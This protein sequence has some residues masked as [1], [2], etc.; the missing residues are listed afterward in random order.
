MPSFSVKGGGGWV[1]AEGYRLHWLA[2]N[3]PARRSFGGRRTPG[4]ELPGAEEGRTGVSG[5]GRR[6]GPCPGV[7]SLLGEDVE[8]R[9]AA[10]L[11]FQRDVME[12]VQRIPGVLA[13][14]A[15]DGLPF[16]GVVSG[17]GY[18]V[19]APDGENSMQVMARNHRVSRGYSAWTSPFFLVGSWTTKG[20]LL[21]PF[22]RSSST[23]PWPTLL[24][25]ASPLDATIWRN[26]MP[27]R[28]GRCG[29]RAGTE[30]GSRASTH[31]LPSSFGDHG[32]VQRRGSRPGSAG[33]PGATAQGGR[34]FGQ[35]Q[36]LCPRK[37]P[38]RP[39]S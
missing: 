13:S 11:E 2:E 26:R 20:P 3:W 30:S 36:P 8:G 31:G 34:A 37:T 19:G 21:I 25:E 32:W 17:N 7:F 14:G 1:V 15:I 6:H 12:R 5:P 23:K 22:P 39:S 9:R 35:P 27:S 29:R 24:P 28:S 18:Q 10:A 33:G 16:P 38:W 4:P